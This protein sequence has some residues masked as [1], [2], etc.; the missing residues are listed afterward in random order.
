MEDWWRDVVMSGCAIVTVFSPD[1]YMKL[2]NGEEGYCF[3]PL[4]P[5]K[6]NT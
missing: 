6:S 1:E 3:R 4:P 5:Q 2:V